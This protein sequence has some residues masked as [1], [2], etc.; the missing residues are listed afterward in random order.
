[1][2]YDLMN[3]EADIEAAGHRINYKYKGS[4]YGLLTNGDVTYENNVITVKGTD[5]YLTPVR[6]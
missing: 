4:R 3:S 1:M 5:I 2:T 6:Q